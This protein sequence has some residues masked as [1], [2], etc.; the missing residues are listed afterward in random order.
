M[1]KFNRELNGYNKQ[2][3]NKFLNDT[4][5]Q[6]EVMLRKAEEQDRRIQEQRKI[7]QTQNQKLTEQA[8]TIAKINDQLIHCKSIENTLQK[9][10]FSAEETGNNIRRNASKEA[11]LI[12]QEARQN[13]SR[14]VNDSLLRAEKVE[15]Q[16]DTAERNLRIFKK[17]LRSIVEQQEA[18]VEEI[19]ELELK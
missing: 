17:K 13:A 4:I 19:E 2:E 9:A 11:A 12:I 3:V 15:L 7:I 16:T 1:E 5:V 14:I 18:V 6:L 10:I 8:T